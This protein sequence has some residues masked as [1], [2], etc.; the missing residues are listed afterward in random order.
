MYV[1]TSVCVCV[2]MD[3]EVSVHVRTCVS[4]YV[5]ESDC[6]IESVV[7]SF[8]CYPLIKFSV[9]FSGIGRNCFV[10]YCK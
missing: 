8:V 5:Y 7:D 9:V 4:E 6:I 1:C 2:S 3:V 10:F